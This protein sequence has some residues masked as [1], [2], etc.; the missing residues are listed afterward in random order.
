MTLIPV[1]NKNLIEANH[2]PGSAGLPIT[3]LNAPRIEPGAS[4][5]RRDELAGSPALGNIASMEPAGC[6]CAGQPAK[7]YTVQ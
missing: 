3:P 1:K 4:E 2:I 6:E 5:C 7:E